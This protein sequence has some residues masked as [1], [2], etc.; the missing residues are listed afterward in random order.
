MSY[1]FLNKKY[2]NQFQRFA[3][4]VPEI[5]ECFTVG[6]AF[7]FFLKVVS[8]NMER[9][10]QIADE[11]IDCIDTEIH[12]NT[13]VIMHENKSLKAYPLDILV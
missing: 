11:L 13:H 5:L 8:P 7:D 4:T 1:L 9:Y 3:N 12:L 2:F 10:L 6:G